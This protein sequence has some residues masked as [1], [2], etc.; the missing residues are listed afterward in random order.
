M[1][2]SLTRNMNTSTLAKPLF[3]D[4][5]PQTKFPGVHLVLRNLIQVQG[6]PVDV[7]WVRSHYKAI[8][9]VLVRIPTSWVESWGE[10]VTLPV[11]FDS[12]TLEQLEDAVRGFFKH[13]DALSKCPKCGALTYNRKHYPSEY[14]DDDCSPCWFKAAQARWDKAAKAQEARDKKKDAKKLAEGYTHKL[15][16]VVHPAA[17]GDDYVIEG[18]MPAPPKPREVE[19]ILRKRKSAILND[20]VVKDLATGALIRPPRASP[21]PTGA[22]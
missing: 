1:D 4:R 18:Y 20:Y 5:D 11:P 10:N 9:T 14:R 3:T 7:E 6:V 21:A 22:G 15:R 17:G 13:P 19:A 8:D 16:A 12:C 2:N